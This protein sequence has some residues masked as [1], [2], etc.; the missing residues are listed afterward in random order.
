MEFLCFVKA[1]IKNIFC[2][3]KKS[4]P[5]FKLNVYASINYNKLAFITKILLFYDYFNY[6]DIGLMPCSCK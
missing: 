5:G 1:N 4:H 6:Q 3:Q 2:K